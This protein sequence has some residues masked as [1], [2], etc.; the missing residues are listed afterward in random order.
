MAQWNPD[1][2]LAF[3]DHRSRPYAELLGRVPT[4]VS[5]TRIADLGCGPG[6]LS[7]LLRHRWS[8]AGIL[9]V[10]SSAE[11]INRANADNTDPRTTYEL[12]DLT[13][14]SPPESYELIISNA[15]FQWVPGDLAVIQRLSAH[16]RPGGCFAISV[17]NN[18]AAP[19]HQLLHEISSRPPYRDHTDGLHRARGRDPQSLLSLFA[20]GGWQVDAWTTIYHQVLEGEDPVLR[21]VCGTGARPI[22]QALPEPLRTEFIATYGAALREAYPQRSYGT[23]L[24]FERTF[25][26]AVRP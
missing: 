3:A 6:H 11:M 21:W 2:Y 25:C 20:E 15:T 16:V 19:N 24:P 10:D 13:D 17:P 26:V 5:P 7:A 18:F 14:W 23:V 12:A 22:L 8:E 1:T 9:G 4:T